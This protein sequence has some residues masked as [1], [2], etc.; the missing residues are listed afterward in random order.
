ME[1]DRRPRNLKG[2]FVGTLLSLFGKKIF[3]QQLGETLRR[4]EKAEGSPGAAA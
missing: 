4:V 1:F 3:S 2:Y